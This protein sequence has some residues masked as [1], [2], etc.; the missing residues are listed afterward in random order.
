MLL[1]NII[2]MVNR[3]ELKNIINKIKSI[4]TLKTELYDKL[5]EVLLELNEHYNRIED[6]NYNY[7]HN[8]MFAPYLYLGASNKVNIKEYYNKTKCNNIIL[9]FLNYDTGF[10]QWSDGIN[11]YS[12]GIDE[13]V[14]FIHEKQGNIIISSGGA[15]G[16]ELTN[17]MSVDECVKIYKY[18]Y[19]VYQIKHFDFDIEGIYLGNNS[20]VLKRCQ[21][22]K[23]IKKQVPNAIIQYTIPISPDGLHNDSKNLLI[24]S[25]QENVIPDIINLMTMDFG[26]YYAPNGNTDMAKYCIQCIENVEK[27]LK[28]YYIE[29]K[30]GVTPMI[31]LNDCNDEVFSLSNA[32]ELVSYC[33]NKNNIKLLSFWCIN[34]D[35]GSKPNCNY[36]DCNFSSIEQKLF[37]FSCIFNNKS[38]E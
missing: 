17:K 29:S 10:P 37:E 4:I 30:I 33:K 9:A 1:E 18:F 11:Y 23:E 34:R 19:D 14:H 25:K 8:Y 13:V 38:C 16:I 31:G 35:N 15:N 20:L 5:F 27:Q 28:E 26:I 24:T 32:R 22:I 36:A 21:L 3:N 6:E 12:G 7:S 2:N